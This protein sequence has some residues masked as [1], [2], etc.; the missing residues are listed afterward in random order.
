M[1]EGCSFI[2]HS[3]MRSAIPVALI[4]CNFACSLF[5]SPADA[6]ARDR[7]F[8]ASYGSDSNPCTFGS[9]CKTFQ[10]AINSVAVNGEVTAIDSAGFGP[11]TITQSVT[12]TSPPGVEAGI[13][14]TPG[15]NA[16]TIN[17]T[18]DINVTLRS[19]TLEGNGNPGVGIS[20]TSSVAAL[21]SINIID[22]TVANFLGG[23]ISLQ[24][25]SSVPDNPQPPIM[26]ILIANTSVINNG[27]N[28][29]TIAPGG[30]AVAY[31]TISQAMVADNN[32]DGI[33]ISGGSNIDI[34]NS[35]SSTNGTGV[36]VES[37]ALVRTFEST[38][39]T[40]IG[41]DVDVSGNAT[42]LLLSHNNTLGLLRISSNGTVKSDG[43]SYIATVASGTITHVNLQ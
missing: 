41:D 29:I 5:A 26:R 37:G 14:A 21:A 32:A 2:G 10:Q 33:E 42:T 1:R 4:A 23:G 16:I 36:A 6:A 8:V 38:V 40:S 11:V 19:L 27:A 7:V 31:G 15:Q 17:A 39:D 24:P 30:T 20:L 28:G 25:T 35:A 22:C 12:I 43:T 3:A 34:R 9:P 13:V 18:S